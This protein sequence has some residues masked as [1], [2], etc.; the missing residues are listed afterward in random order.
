MK[1][2]ILSVEKFLIPIL[3]DYFTLQGASPIGQH[4]NVVVTTWTC[5]CSVATCSTKYTNMYMYVYIHCRKYSTFTHAQCTCACM[6][7]EHGLSV[8]ACYMYLESWYESC[9][10]LLPVVQ[11][12]GRRDNEKGTPSLLML[13]RNKDILWIQ[14][15]K[16]MYSTCKLL[17]GNQEHILIWTILYVHVPQPDVLGRQCSARSFPVPSHQPVSHWCLGHRGWPT[18]S[19]PSTGR[20]SECP[21][22]W[23][24]GGCL[25]RRSAWVWPSWSSCQLCVIVETRQR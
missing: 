23:W 12:W 20:P 19:Y 8:H 2:G 4:L 3:P 11:C 13:Q 5:T 25:D 18:S 1:R 10:L 6:L 15:I 24:A 9:A 14:E 16:L 17:L 21:W 7:H 22:R